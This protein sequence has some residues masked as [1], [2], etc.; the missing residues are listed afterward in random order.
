[1]LR[2]GFDRN[3]WPKNKIRDSKT[4]QPKIRESETQ[5]NTRK[6]DFETHSKHIQDFD[7]GTKFLFGEILTKKERIRTLGFTLAY[8]NKI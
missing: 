4:S 6:R 3:R 2:H 1:M 7:T 8:N 5:T